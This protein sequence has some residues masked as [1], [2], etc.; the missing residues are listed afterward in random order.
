MT[1][2]MPGVRGSSHLTAP[3]SKKPAKKVAVK[4]KA[5]KKAKE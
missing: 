4:K 3:T 5:A 1:K 2:C